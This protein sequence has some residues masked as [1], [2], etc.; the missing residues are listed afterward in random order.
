MKR[1][2]FLAALAIVLFSS[3]AKKFTCSCPLPDDINLP[4]ARV[5]KSD[6]KSGS[7]KNALTKCI[8]KYK[9]DNTNGTNSRYCLIE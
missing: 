9:K 6:I 4:P 2:I 7:S 8:E 5:Q 1:P 3:C